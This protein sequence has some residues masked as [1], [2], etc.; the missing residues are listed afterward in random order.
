MNMWPES[1]PVPASVAGFLQGVGR[2]NPVFDLNLDQV[3]LAGDRHA[4]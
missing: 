1:L 4:E 3:R 2:R